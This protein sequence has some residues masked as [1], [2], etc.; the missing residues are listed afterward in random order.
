MPVANR[1]LFERTH[2]LTMSEP[3]VF[4]RTIDQTWWGWQGQFGGYVLALA[5][6]AFRASVTDPSHREISMSLHFLRRVAAGELR[7]EVDVVRVGRT[8]TNLRCTMSVDDKTVAIGI[9]LFGSDRESDEYQLAETPE[10]VIPTSPPGP[11]LIPATAM[12]HL[13]IWDGP[14]DG[15]VG[16]MRLAESG[17]ADE[18]FGL[19]AADGMLPLSFGSNIR[20]HTGGTVDFTAHFREQFPQ[21]IVDGEEP[22]AVVLRTGRSF[23]GYVDED[24]ELWSADGRLLMQTRQTRYSEYAPVDIIRELSNG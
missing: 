20:P 2:D 22:V 4:E 24:A 7:I 16:W 8:I 14:S 13:E 19:F 9:A 11:S 5:L 3:G 15:R 6:D 10:L 21:A 1:S 12:D 23:R 17:G 18:R